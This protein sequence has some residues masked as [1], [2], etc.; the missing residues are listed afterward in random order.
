MG[1]S[2]AALK[3]NARRAAVSCNIETSGTGGPWGARPPR[4][5]GQH[6]PVIGASR[7]AMLREFTVFVRRYPDVCLAT[8]EQAAAKTS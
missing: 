1:G 7:L 4:W 6:S 5:P 3:G 8:G 2:A